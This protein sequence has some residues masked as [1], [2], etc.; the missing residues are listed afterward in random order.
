MG[1]LK[2]TV[3]LLH[4]PLFYPLFLR[5]FAQSHDIRGLRNH[6]KSC[7]VFPHFALQILPYLT[8]EYIHTDVEERLHPTLED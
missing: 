4:S 2:I 6:T 7:F 3:S 1:V 8:I 5:D